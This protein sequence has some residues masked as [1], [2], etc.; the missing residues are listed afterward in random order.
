MSITDNGDNTQNTQSPDKKRSELLA[1]KVTPCERATIYRKAKRCGLTISS[2][3]R[4]RALDYE[5]PARLSAEE[6]QLLANLATARTDI[7]NFSNALHGLSENEKY[8]LFRD[9]RCMEQWYRKI[10][11]VTEAVNRYLQC[12]FR[13]K[14]FAPATSN[15]N[16][17]DTDT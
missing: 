5:P 17:N 14:P 12:A 6:K 3:I 10:A 16:D 9:N 1:T 2:Y 7:V 13:S 15:T 11:P 8:Y 4:S